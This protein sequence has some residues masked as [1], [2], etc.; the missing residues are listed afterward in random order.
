MSQNKF[1]KNCQII[2]Y[3]IIETFYNREQNYINGIAYHDLKN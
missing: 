3:I 1:F 2:F